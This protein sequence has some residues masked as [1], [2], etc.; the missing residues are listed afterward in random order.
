MWSWV[1]KAVVFVA[2]HKGKISAVW[3]IYR[4]LRKSRGESQQD[5]ED[6]KSYY[7][8]RAVQAAKDVLENKEEE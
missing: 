1:A 5:G 7:K 2:E 4:Q 8:R 6:V 3:Q